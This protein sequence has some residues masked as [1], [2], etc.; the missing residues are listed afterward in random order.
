MGPLL[1]LLCARAALK[2]SRL[3]NMRVTVVN[4][5][6]CVCVWCVVCVWCDVC[7]CVK[8]KLHDKNRHF[9]FRQKADTNF[10]H[11]AM[12]VCLCLCVCMCVYV[13]VCVF[14][15][16]RMYDWYT[17]TT[18]I[19]THTHTHIHTHKQTKSPSPNL[20]TRTSPRSYS[21]SHGTR[22]ELMKRFTT[23]T[24]AN[25]DPQYRYPFLRFARKEYGEE[26]SD[27]F[28][29]L[30]FWFVHF[31]FAFVMALPVVIWLYYNGHDERDQLFLRYVCVRVCVCVCGC[32]CVCV[33]CVCVCS[34][35][36]F[37]YKTHIFTYKLFSHTRT[38][39]H[40][41]THTHTHSR[42][43][44]WHTEKQFNTN[45]NNTNISIIVD[46]WGVR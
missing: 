46:V 43:S 5:M 24:H 8:C 19:H 6:V 44:L 11:S 30:I 10:R 25:T 38:H 32:E 3:D 33:L 34:L 42:L 31:L 22:D 36:F 28:E 14:V 18:H 37:L 40:A 23:L 20:R 12:E 35:V 9:T 41:H 17:H 29:L 4:M 39:T 16:I 2:N 26:V 45:N 13:C 7:V 27:Y 15:C 21:R 1:K